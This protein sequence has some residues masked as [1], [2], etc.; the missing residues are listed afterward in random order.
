MLRSCGFK[1]PLEASE[2]LEEFS[3]CK[4]SVKQTV[5]EHS[6]GTLVFRAYHVNASRLAVAAVQSRAKRMGPQ[7]ES[8]V[9]WSHED[10][11]S[12]IIGTSQVMGPKG[13]PH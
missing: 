8:P 10:F 11:L 1:A 2:L 3:E 7:N 5:L 6:Q 13:I 12:E 9:G 4:H